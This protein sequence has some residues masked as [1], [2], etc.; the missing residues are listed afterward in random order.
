M[1]MYVSMAA[2]LT[3]WMSVYVSMVVRLTTWLSFLTNWEF[4]NRRSVPEEHGCSG[5]RNRS[6][7][8]ERPK[9][10]FDILQ[11]AA[12]PITIQFR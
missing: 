6:T 7:S 9:Q 5:S 12:L 10:N 11:K 8:E 3:S 1:S 2:S 4:I